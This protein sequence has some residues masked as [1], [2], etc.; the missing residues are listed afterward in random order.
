MASIN[1]ITKQYKDEG[2]VIAKSIFSKELLFVNKV[3]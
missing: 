2:Y 1:K 3:F